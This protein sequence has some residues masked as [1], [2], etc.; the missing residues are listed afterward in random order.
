[1]K[2]VLGALVLATAVG[3]VGS[4]HAQVTIVSPSNGATYSGPMV[5]VGFYVNCPGGQYKAEWKF[6][7][8]TSAGS[9]DFYDHASVRFMQKMPSGK[10][11]FK[12]GSASCGSASVT[13]KV[14]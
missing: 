10:Y 14:Q 9:V 8:G 3:F 1:M 11:V 5:P 6:S 12:V 13:F 4:A 2:T 7:V